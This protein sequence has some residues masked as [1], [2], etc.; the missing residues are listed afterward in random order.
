MQ[1]VL[2]A[3][4][5]K[6]LIGTLETIPGIAMLAGEIGPSDLEDIP[7]EGTTDLDWNSQKPVYKE[8]ANGEMHRVFVDEA[9]DLWRQDQLV[10]M[11]VENA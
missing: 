5:G 7:Y 3:P 11:E 8:D 9:S 1:K 10:E 4:N 2:R 6:R